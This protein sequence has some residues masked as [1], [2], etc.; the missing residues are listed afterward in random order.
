MAERYGKN[1]HVAAWQID[2]EYDCHDT[3]LS[4]SEAAKRG[5]Q[6]WLAQKYQST[7]ALNRAWGNVFWSMDYD[8][9]DQIELP[10]LTVTEPNHPH[11]NWPSASIPQIK[12][13]RSTRCKPAPFAPIRTHR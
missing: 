2:N 13:W 7:A 9:F 4:Y 1:P 3:T 12:S 5:F 6:D 11:T 8:T 10:N